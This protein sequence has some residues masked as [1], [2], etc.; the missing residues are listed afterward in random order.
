MGVS[1]FAMVLVVFEGR[2]TRPLA[3]LGWV[4][5]VLLGWARYALPEGSPA[6]LEVLQKLPLV[7]F[8]G[9][10]AALILRDVFRQRQIWLELLRPPETDSTV[11]VSGSTPLK[12]SACRLRKSRQVLILR[13]RATLKKLTMIEPAIQGKRITIPAR[14]RNATR[15]RTLRADAENFV[16]NAANLCFNFSRRVVTMVFPFP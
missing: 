10:A 8:D 12:A 2:R 15:G 1:F 7:L 13:Q 14:I 11:R 3:L 16:L 4:V 6:W 5:V 9:W